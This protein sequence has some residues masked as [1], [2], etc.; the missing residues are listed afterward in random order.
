MIKRI[1][2]SKA[3]FLTRSDYHR[4]E[5][6]VRM[7]EDNEHVKNLIEISGCEP[8]LFV[9]LFG[10]SDFKFQGEYLVDVWT[11]EYGHKQ[12]AIISANERGTT[13]EGNYE[14]V[15]N[16]QND[17]KLLKKFISELSEMIKEKRKDIKNG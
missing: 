16:P 15:D 2:M 1:H 14:F 5:Y 7:N 10:K 11:F 13:I 3:V 17:I 12:F 9:S 8:K 6:L 4:V